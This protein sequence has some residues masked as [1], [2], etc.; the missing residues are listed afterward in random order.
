MVSIHPF[1]VDKVRINQE[2]V[3]LIHFGMILFIKV[4]KLRENNSMILE[5]RAFITQF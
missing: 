4:D 5:T 1:H 3:C 2:K